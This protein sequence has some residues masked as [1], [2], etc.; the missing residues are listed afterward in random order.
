MDTDDFRPGL[1][2]GWPAQGIDIV[3]L[4]EDH[5]RLAEALAVRK[6]YGREAEVHIAQRIGE[7]ALAG[8]LAGVE[9]WRQIAGA[10]S[11]IDNS[12]LQ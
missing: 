3:A 10:L 6:R 2:R 9:R 4:T 5:W 12:T 11:T 1:V 7:L 8:D